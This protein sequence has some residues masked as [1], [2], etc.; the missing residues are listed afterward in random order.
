[1]SDP[2]SVVVFS[3]RRAGSTAFWE[4]FRSGTGFHC[5]DEPFNPFIGMS[6]VEHKKGVRQEFIDLY[7]GDPIKFKAM[8]SPINR[9]EELTDSLSLDQL[10]Y[11]SWL[12]ESS[13]GI[14]V[15]DVTR[16]NFKVQQIADN[17]DSSV[18]IYLFRSARNSVLSHML[19]SDRWDF[20]DVRRKISA[21][22]IYTRNGGF[23]RWG[24]E[25]LLSGNN[26][27]VC[28]RKMRDY[29]IT[30][31][32]GQPAYIRLLAYWLLNYRIANSMAKVGS[33]GMSLV[34]F[35]EFAC[36]PQE[37]L[38]RSVPMLG[39]SFVDRMDFSQLRSGGDVFDKDI[40][41]WERAAKELGFTSEELRY[42][43]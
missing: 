3:M 1:M 22:S 40:S 41:V 34:F 26:L 32:D 5:F 42:L 6:P 8:Y 19:P 21:K 10:R 12:H 15:F 35:D 43:V 20:F 29:G 31:S 2:A 13:S 37:Y 30:L 23:N 36:A 7:I 24:Y 11:F 4:C 14:P 27:A 28:K 38:V 16:C 39:Q 9:A 25:E 17:F 33:I 18:F